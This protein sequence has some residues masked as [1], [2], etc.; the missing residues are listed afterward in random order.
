[1]LLRRLSSDI[2]ANG[3]TLSLS[4][5]LCAD[6][7]AEASVSEMVIAKELL[8]GNP[9]E[10]ARLRRADNEPLYGAVSDCLSLYRHSSYILN[11]ASTM[12][13]ATKEMKPAKLFFRI[14]GNVWWLLTASLM[15]LSNMQFCGSDQ[16]AFCMCLNP[17]RR[18]DRNQGHRGGSCCG[19][20]CR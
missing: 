13:C 18:S 1:M 10:K 14:Y 17:R 20:N 11:A 15:S 19:Q 9:V 12:C 3:V 7:G 16:I 2:M 8:R 4:R 5:R 6:F